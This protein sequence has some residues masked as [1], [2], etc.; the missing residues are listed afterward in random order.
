[1]KE[2]VARK[3]LRKVTK[4]EGEISSDVCVCGGGVRSVVAVVAAVG[5]WR[6]EFGG[7]RLLGW[8]AW[9]QGMGR[10]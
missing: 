5:L 6:W 7:S 8:A 10:A 4:I 2:R 1:M 9:I 3:M